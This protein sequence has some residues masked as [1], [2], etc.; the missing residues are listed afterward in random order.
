[1]LLVGLGVPAE[2]SEGERL[3]RRVSATFLI[4]VRRAR[5]YALCVKDSL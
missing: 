4:K 2:P 1:L 5:F 3:T